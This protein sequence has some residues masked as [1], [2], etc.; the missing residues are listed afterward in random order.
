M[1]ISYLVSYYVTVPQLFLCRILPESPRWLNQ[2]KEHKK[3]Q[4]VLRKIAQRNKR[5]M[6]SID[7]LREAA[8]ADLEEAK[9]LKKFTYLDL[10]R[11]REYTKRTVILILIWQAFPGIQ[12]C[13]TKILRKK[14]EEFIFFFK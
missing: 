1:C 8:R 14:A 11:Y 3:A 9:N 7:V 12:T 6:P 4:K 5:P 10:F 13:P 2:H